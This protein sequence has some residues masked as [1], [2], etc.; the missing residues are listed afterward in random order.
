MKK[1]KHNQNKDNH[2]SPK[3]MTPQEIADKLI[4]ITGIDPFYKSREPEV[5]EVR[6]F[7]L[8]LLRGKLNMRWIAI[9]EFFLQN[10]RKTDNSSIINSYN[11]YD[12]YSRGSKRLKK[13]EKEFTFNFTETVDE[14]SKIQVLE[15]R[16][17]IL[18]RKIKNC[19]AQ[20]KKDIQP[21][22]HRRGT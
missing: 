9:K 3:K 17:R 6:S 22:I 10:G 11:N 13:L 2:L 7:L 5:I 8:F 16:C 4:V 12:N 19:E 18:S 14:I 15:N 1:T 20:I 21:I